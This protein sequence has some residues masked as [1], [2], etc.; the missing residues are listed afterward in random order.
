MSE[1]DNLNN[2]SAD[3]PPA[4][5][6]IMP[7]GKHKGRSLDQIAQTDDGL[8]YLDWA[9]GA[10]DPG[11]ELLAIERYLSDPVMER[12]VEAALEKRGRE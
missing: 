3:Q 1:I 10:F 11:D 8:R 7:F 9:R 4:G 2:E 12:E 5:A 6:F